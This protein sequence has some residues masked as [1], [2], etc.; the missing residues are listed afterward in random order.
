MLRTT[1][2]VYLVYEFCNGGT[3]EEMIHKKKFFNETDSLFAFK[4]ILDAFEVLFK[5]NILHRDL[6]P[7]N[8]LLNDGVIKVAD[9]GFCKTLLGPADLT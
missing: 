4:Q 5:E 2:N 3:L 8:I 9:F 1:N 7:S 6:K